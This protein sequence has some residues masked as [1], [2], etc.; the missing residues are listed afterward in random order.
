MPIV[1]DEQ[2]FHD[3]HALLQ[4]RFHVPKPR[5]AA[6]AVC[7]ESHPTFTGEQ[8]GGMHEVGG[9][10]QSGNALGICS[11]S[12]S[13]VRSLEATTVYSR[14]PPMS[15]VSPKHCPGPSSPTRCPIS[16]T[17][18]PSDSTAPV[19]PLKARKSCSQQQWEQVRR[20]GWTVLHR[21]QAGNP[22]WWTRR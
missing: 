4:Q 2:P 20:H 17:S 7:C 19:V 3:L 18:A 15:L 22:P 21:K 11:R 13:V 10:R 9:T 14:R 6:Q 5:R 16:F 8:V 1:E 12:T